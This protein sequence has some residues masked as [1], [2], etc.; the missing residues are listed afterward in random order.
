MIM[1]QKSL[2]NIGQK[3]LDSK[4]S[5]TVENVTFRKLTSS[6]GGFPVNQSV[7]QED[8]R[9]KQ[10]K[11]GSGQNL[12]VSFANLSPDGYWLKTWR[13]YYQ[14]TLEG[15]LERFSETWPTAGI[16]LH[17]K[18]CRLEPLVHHT[19]GDGSLSLP[20]VTANESKG[21][22]KKRYRGSPNFRGAKMSEGLRTCE[23]DPIYL[24]PSFA[25][26]TMGFPIGW[27][28]LEMP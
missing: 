10:T 5:E 14:S 11:D 18:C 23:T 8:V 16:M 20:T 13:D 7:T 12:L 17:G 3:S 28:L 6:A 19:S 1:R 26:L 27:T 22:G 9:H 2:K 25:E 21:S 4:M 15:H 24:N